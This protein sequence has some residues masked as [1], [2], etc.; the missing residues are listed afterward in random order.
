MLSFSVMGVRVFELEFVL[1]LWLSNGLKMYYLFV[2][3]FNI[4]KKEDFFCIW[5]LKIDLFWEFLSRLFLCVKYNFFFVR[6][7]GKF[8][9]RSR[10]DMSGGEVFFF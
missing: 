2:Y 6:V 3:I 8:G 1:F 5:Y 10:K 9:E 4:L 7:L